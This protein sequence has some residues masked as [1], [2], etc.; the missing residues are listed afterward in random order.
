MPKPVPFPFLLDALYPFEPV[1]R[2]MFGCHALYRGEKILLILRDRN[3]HTDSN[4]IWIATDAEHHES[5]RKEFPCLQSVHILS[6]GKGETRWQMIP[7]DDDDFE[8]LAI[9]LCELVKAEDQRIGRVPKG[10]KKK[11]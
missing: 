10:K 9:R 4:G 1:I 6:D 11:K 8:T 2:P 3:D 5:L 7:M